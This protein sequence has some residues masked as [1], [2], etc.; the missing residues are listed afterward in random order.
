MKKKS[1]YYRCNGDDKIEGPFT[2]LIAVRKAILEN[3]KECFDTSCNCLKREV[4]GNWFDEIEV[5]E[6][7]YTVKPIVK[8][9]LA[10]QEVQP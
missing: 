9:M 3:A 8:S 7:V 10:L 2:S 1:F 5:F 4:N 6:R